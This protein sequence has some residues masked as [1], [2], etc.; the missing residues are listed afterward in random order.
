MLFR[1]VLGT[2]LILLGLLQTRLWI[3]EDGLGEV[4]RLRDQIYSQSSENTQLADR[5]KRLGAEVED[6]KSGFSALEERARAD[7]GLIGSDETF[8][9][10]GGSG[11]EEAQPLPEK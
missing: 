6:L 2:L 9:V 8:F 5:N 10:V 4:S 1:V 3:S 7:L 11:P